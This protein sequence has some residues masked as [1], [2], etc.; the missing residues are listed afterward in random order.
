MYNLWW[1]V[2]NSCRLSRTQ[3]YSLQGKLSIKHLPYF[4]LNR[5]TN[6]CIKLQVLSGKTCMQCKGSITTEEQFF[7]HIQQHSSPQNGTNNNNSSQNSL[8][9]PTFC[10]ICRQ[11]L[12]SEMEARMHARFH[13][14]Q[15]A[16]LVPCSVCFHM[17]ERQDLIAG[18]CKDCYQRHGKSSP[19]RCP[20]CHMKFD[21]GTAI[22]IH[23]ATVH[24]KSYQC[25]KCQVRYPYFRISTY[26]HWRFRVAR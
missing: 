18:I 4:K 3:A 1:N 20:E 19:F 23:L 12:S 17:S 24:R 9:L 15:S 6:Q 16:D 25:I 14:H 26:F 10:V 7:S 22:E 5:E 13:L 2:S 8:V 11:T 21:N